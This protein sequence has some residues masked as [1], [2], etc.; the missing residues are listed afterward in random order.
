MYTRNNN[1][2]IALI[3]ILFFAYI[4]SCTSY[5]IQ[6]D[7][8]S[9]EDSIFISNNF[10]KKLGYNLKEYD[11]KISEYNKPWN[12]RIKTDTSSLYPIETRK[13]LE[14]KVY[15]RVDYSQKKI[16]SKNRNTILK[17]YGGDI[18][19]FIDKMTGEILTAYVEE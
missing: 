7:V 16:A 8:V 12:N 11:I 4:T 2:L 15:W 3:Y 9:K 6:K 10:L 13:K 19:V 17:Q 18:S 14:S 5:M 1:F